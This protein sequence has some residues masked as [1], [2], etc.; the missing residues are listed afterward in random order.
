M[1]GV[2]WAGLRRGSGT[3][4]SRPVSPNHSIEATSQSPLRAVCAAA[5]VER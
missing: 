4:P 5:H 2:A 3:E 1:R